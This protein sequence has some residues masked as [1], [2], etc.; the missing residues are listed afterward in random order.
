MDLKQIG[1]E[2]TLKIKRDDTIL[3]LRLKAQTASDHPF[4]GL[5]YKK[6]PRYLVIGGLVFTELSQN[7]L[8]TWGEEWPRK[9]P[10]LLRYL[11]NHID[12]DK[13]FAEFR[14]FVVLA[15]R[16]P[17]EINMYADGFQNAVVKKVNN[18][19]ILSFEDFQAQLQKLAPA[20]LSIDFFERDEALFLPIAGLKE[21]HK[22]INKSY[23][24]EPEAWFDRTIDGAVTRRKD[25]P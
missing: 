4:N 15:R 18:T 20:F 23:G 24:V 25:S 7:Y 22:E 21:T 9:I 17:H 1:E 8:E 12:E 10:P 5:T 14:S 6:H 11:F 19:P 13:M 3:N 16:L 2:F